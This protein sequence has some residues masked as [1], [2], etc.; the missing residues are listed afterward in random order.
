MKNE[1]NQ[2]TLDKA[3]AVMSKTRRAFAELRARAISEQPTAGVTDFL[4][5]KATKGGVSLHPA[6]R[7]MAAIRADEEI[8]RSVSAYISGLI[9]FDFFCRRPHLI[10]SKLMKEPIAV[11]ERI[12]AELLASGVVPALL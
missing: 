3:Q 9:V 8:Y 2:L 10:T 12:F 11:R 7:K 1:I 6:V 4:H 5:L